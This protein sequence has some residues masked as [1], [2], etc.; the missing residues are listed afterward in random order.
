MYPEGAL[1][2]SNADGSQKAQMEL[3]GAA[4]LASANIKISYRQRELPSY[5]FPEMDDSPLTRNLKGLYGFVRSFPAQ[6]EKVRDQFLK[7]IE[8]L[9]SECSIAIE[10]EPATLDK[11][12]QTLALEL[13]AILFV[14]PDTL[15]SQSDLQHF[16]DKN[17]QLII[18][19]SGDCAIDRLEVTI[20]AVYFDGNQEQ[21]SEDQKQ[22]KSN[23]ETLVEE[24][25]IPLN[26]NLPYIQAESA[27][28]LRSPK[29]IAQRLCIVATTNLVAFDTILPEEAVD[30]LKESN[31]WEL[32]TAREKEFLADPTEERKSQETWKCEGIW[33]L[34]WSLNKL[35]TLGFPDELCDLGTIPAEEYPIGPDKN[36]NEFINSISE[37]RSKKEI[38]DTNDLY[39]R[40]HWA[41]VDASIKG[42]ELTALHPGVVYERLYAL[43]WLIHYKNQDWDQVSCDS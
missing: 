20:D 42:E 5:R 16:L 30:Y 2:L 36:P 25:K 9:N 21:G 17:L 24:K 19:P 11:L 39:Y 7:K 15:I 1:T 8:T 29:E 37:T 33:T 13:D 6:N 43:N 22:R 14:Q 40:L 35:E 18:D 23:T 31:L 27:T 10:G 26:R 38:L 41:S 32:T 34:L 3:K 4:N 28:V 12:I